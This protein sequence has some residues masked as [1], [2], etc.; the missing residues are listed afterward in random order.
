M[1]SKV[2]GKKFFI[3]FYKI[4]IFKIDNFNLILKEDKKCQIGGDVGSSLW[5]NILLDLIQL[6]LGLLLFNYNHLLSFYI[7]I[8]TKRLK[9]NNCFNFFNF[10]QSIGFE[11][12]FGLPESYLSGWIVNFASQNLFHKTSKKAYNSFCFSK[13]R[14][15][16]VLCLL[17]IRSLLAAKQETWLKIQPQISAR[18]NYYE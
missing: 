12:L 3:N 18:C 9:K 13:Q 10:R 1:L 8:L 11:N 5:T 16:I 15:T 17:L 7:E 4:L 6:I 14:N 2:H